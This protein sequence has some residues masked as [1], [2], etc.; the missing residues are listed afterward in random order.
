[1]SGRIVYFQPTSDYDG[2]LVLIDADRR[3]VRPIAKLGKLWPFALEWRP[4]GRSVAITLIPWDHGGLLR[5]DAVRV[6][7]IETGAVTDLAEKPQPMCAFPSWGASG[8]LTLWCYSGPTQYGITRTLVVAGKPFEFGQVSWGGPRAS[9]LSRAATSP[10]GSQV[11]FG[12]MEDMDPL[13]SYNGGGPALWRMDVSTGELALVLGFGFEH[14]MDCLSNF[15]QFLE[16]VF[17]PAGDTIAVTRASVGST[18]GG[19]Y[20]PATG[21]LIVV[22]AD[23]SGVRWFSR[24][25]YWHAAWSPDGKS[26]LVAERDFDLR[27]SQLVLLDATTGEATRLTANGGYV[28]AWTR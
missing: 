26:L 28:A 11:A 24:G 16:P 21:G 20:S 15:D 27:R 25:D 7:D 1:L 5:S 22:A 6:V 3:Q 14:P 13:C 2:Q 8:V 4:D 10:D 12:G 23:G 18:S 19:I 9:G 17:S